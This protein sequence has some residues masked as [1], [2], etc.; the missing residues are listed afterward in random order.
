MQRKRPLACFVT[1]AVVAALV[2]AA[3]L[4]GLTLTPAGA[5]SG[6]CAGAT[7]VSVVVDFTAVPGTG[8]GV[9]KSC[10]ASGNGKTAFEVVAAAGYQQE[11]AKNQ[12]GFVCRIDGFLNSDSCFNASPA[13]AFWGL[14]WSNGNGRWAFASSGADGVTLRDG[15]TVAWAFQ[16][17]TTNAPPRAAPATYVASTPTPKP[18][19]STVIPGAA[20]A[21]KAPK[22][23]PG[24][25][26]PRTQQS[27]AKQPTIPTPTAPAPRVIP[28]VPAPTPGQPSG[29]STAPGG[30]TSPLPSAV[31]P[32]SAAGSATP[33]GLSAAKV[34]SR[35]QQPTEQH[36]GLPAWVP[37]LVIVVLAGAAG[38]VVLLRRRAAG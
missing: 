30:T 21:P 31:A 15:D 32:P 18:T 26:N 14:F 37:V 11:R 27:G 17:S 1:L 34:S 4:L 19:N 25:K 16:D 23:T 22:A 9:E 36:S 13:N 38:A 35:A 28:T 20:G 10:V 33:D 29:S 8:R 2:A 7:G 6:Y 3:G 12:R 5:A 24:A